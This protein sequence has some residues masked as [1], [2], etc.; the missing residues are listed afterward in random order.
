MS[1]NIDIEGLEEL[2]SFIQERIERVQNLELLKNDIGILIQEDIDN[3]FEKES[4]PDGVD[5]QDWAPATEE[6]RRRSGNDLG[7]ILNLNNDLRPSI[8]YETTGN[9][10]KAGVLRGPAYARIHQ[11]GGQTGRNGRTTIPARPYIGLS[12]KILRN[13]QRLIG[14]RT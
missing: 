7:K 14:E 10:I 4:S 9:S 1:M 12:N 5:W 11:K 3:N 13:I 2:N 8:S 6:Y